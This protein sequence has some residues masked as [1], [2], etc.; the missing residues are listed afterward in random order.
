MVVDLQNAPCLSHGSH[1]FAEKGVGLVFIPDSANSKHVNKTHQQV[2]QD[3]A[4]VRQLSWVI[5]QQASL[6]FKDQLMLSQAAYNGR[7][8]VDGAEP[9]QGLCG[10]HTK[11]GGRHDR[12]WAHEKWWFNGIVVIFHNDSGSS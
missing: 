7:A 3:G 12:R 11:S 10:A 9:P 6:V 2:L 5:N 8:G 4:P 1:L